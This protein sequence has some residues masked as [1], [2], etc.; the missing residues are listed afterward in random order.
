MTYYPKSNSVAALGF[1]LLLCAFFTATAQQKV[2]GVIKRNNTEEKGFIRYNKKTGV[3]YFENETNG[4][5][6]T[7]TAK[8]IDGFHFNDFR[9]YIE[10]IPDSSGN[11]KFAQ[12]LAKGA[13]SLYDFNHYYMIVKEGEKGHV[14]PKKPANPRMSKLLF[15]ARTAGN[16]KTYLSEDCVIFPKGRSIGPKE[17]LDIVRKYNECKKV[18]TFTSNI[19]PQI[20]VAPLVGINYSATDFDA[21][22]ENFLSRSSFDPSM[23]YFAGLALI[24]KPAR[25]SDKLILEVRFFFLGNSYKSSSN[26]KT[27]GSTQFHEIEFDLKTIRGTLGV[28]YYLTPAQQGLFF[29]PNL[30][31]Y[32][33]LDYSSS[34]YSYEMLSNGSRIN[35]ISDDDIFDTYNV[36]DFSLAYGLGVGWNK[37]L[38]ARHGL[39]ALLGAE[40]DLGI[41][42]PDASLETVLYHTTTNLYLTVSYSF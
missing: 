28:R 21:S 35:E 8:D 16:I 2:A 1:M 7:L 18:S 39:T 34:R 4:G 11:R 17:L 26:Y 29:N 36:R 20:L 42:R 19:K 41:S 33:I 25:Y 40:R 32:N 14:V 6:Q 23:G 30:T 9:E 31:A 15:L 27:T 22:P 38:S 13:A 3:V 10:S 37:R 12:V 5:Q 24:E